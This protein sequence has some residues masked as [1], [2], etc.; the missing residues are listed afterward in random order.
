[1]TELKP[2]PFCGSTKLKIESKGKNVGWT[3]I[4][5]R[6]DF[7]TYSIRCNVC[8]ARGG[9]AGGKVITSHLYIYRDNMPSWAITRE[10][11]RQKAIEAWDRRYTPPEEI[12]YDYEAE[13]D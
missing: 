6:V 13:D 7:H 3:G 11:L 12:D 2:C 4:D 10:E 5:A 8:H 1:M 9:T